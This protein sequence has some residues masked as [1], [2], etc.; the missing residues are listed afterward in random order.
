MISLH[1]NI[2]HVSVIC[3]EAIM[4][5]PKIKQGRI[6]GEVQEGKS[7]SSLLFQ[8]VSPSSLLFGAISPSSL[9]LDKKFGRSNTQLLYL[10]VK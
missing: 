10:V 1:L 2:L 8:P 4:L 6:W 7:P 3:G 9:N 5:S